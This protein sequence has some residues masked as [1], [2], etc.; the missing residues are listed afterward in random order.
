MLDKAERQCAILALEVIARNAERDRRELLRLSRSMNLFGT[1]TGL[2]SGEKATLAALRDQSKNARRNLRIAGGGGALPFSFATHFADTAAAGGFDMVIGNP[3]WV[4]THNLDQGSRAE[5]RR[6]YSVYRAAAWE[7]G[8]DSAAAGRGFSAQVDVASLFVERSVSLA[9][10]DGCVGLVLPSKLWRSLAGGG[11]RALLQDKTALLEVED[12]TDA[13]QIF[14]AA[15]YPSIVLARRLGLGSPVGAPVSVTVHRKRSVERWSADPAALPFDETPGSPWVLLPS[16]VRAAFDAVV[17]AGIPFAHTAIGRPM[18]GVKSGCNEAFIVAPGT[19]E[20]EMVR[21]LI[22]GEHM[23]Q[24]R[25]A[26]SDERIIW[27]HD[28][29]GRPLRTLPLRTLARLTRFRHELEQRSDARHGARWWSLF[30]TEAA[31]HSRP[32]VVWSDVARAPKAALLQQGDKSV[33]I[34]SCYI[35]RCRSLEDALTLTGLLNSQL[36]AAWLNC[37][38]EPARGGYH[39]YLGWTMAILP[40][41]VDWTHAIARI[42]PL[43]ARAIDGIP[44]SSSE[45]NGAVLEAYRLSEKDVAPLLEWASE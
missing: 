31:D 36:V 15:V 18:L 26:P 28:E 29:S 1:R 24:W 13:R 39:R 16:P 2:A 42:A 21:P 7:S 12:L 11:V 41:P 8:A 45:L 9:R 38:A 27:T 32:R 4:R 44:P 6:N 5:L 23:S 43:A 25:V 33:A 3:P 14:D 40:L 10:A 30:R 20:C 17:R 34:N 37:I 19:V 35:A 22:R